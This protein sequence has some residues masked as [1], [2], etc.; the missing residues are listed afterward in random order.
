MPLPLVLCAVHWVLCRAGLQ[1]L[2]RTAHCGTSNGTRADRQT[3][4]PSHFAIEV[5]ANGHW[6]PLGYE[7]A[8]VPSDAGTINI[9]PLGSGYETAV[10]F[11]VDGEVLASTEDFTV[12][13]PSFVKRDEEPSAAVAP[14]ATSVRESLL[15]APSAAAEAEGKGEAA[16]PAAEPAE[17]A[18][19]ETDEGSL[20]LAPSSSAPPEPTS[21]T[22]RVANGPGKAGPAPTPGATIVANGTTLTLSE[23]TATVE[24]QPAGSTLLHQS[25]LP[26]SSSAG[27]SSGGESHKASSGSP[28]SSGPLRLINDGEELSSPAGAGIITPGTL[29][30][31]TASA[32]PSLHVASGD[33][34]S[35]ILASGTATAGGMGSPGAGG[36][37]GAGGAGADA[38]AGGGVAATQDGGLAVASS[39]PSA[40]RKAAAAD[41]AGANQGSGA[42][43]LRPSVF[44]AV[45]AT[46]AAFTL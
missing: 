32:G 43:T 2:P 37:V 16:A 11:V 3:D 22:A 40:G 28:S 42:A 17:P 25:P 14:A 34:G 41:A 12:Q 1:A 39:S 36:A 31:I 45:A 26:S 6:I 29:T 13:P 7:F 21:E 4:A 8:D 24:V 35:L 46:V 23:D 9:Q 10:R 5:K 30:A 27:E 33:E 20:L 44:V 15:L 38:G 19:T 18:E